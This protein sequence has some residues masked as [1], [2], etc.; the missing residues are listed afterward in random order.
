MIL[1]VVVN[2]VLFINDKSLYRFKFSICHQ[3]DESENLPQM[4]CDLCIIQLNVAYNFKC[5][6]IESDKKLEQFVIEKGLGTTS[7]PTTITS[8]SNALHL[9]H[10]PEHQTAFPSPIP[11]KLET[12]TD[13]MSEITICTNTDSD[14]MLPT[15]TNTSTT[16]TNPS[17]SSPHHQLAASFDSQSYRMVQLSN[18]IIQ[19]STHTDIDFIN[20]YLPTESSQHTISVNTKAQNGI[21]V[22][23]RKNV[24][25]Q[26]TEPIIKHGKSKPTKYPPRRSLR[27]LDN[28]STNLVL[29]ARPLPKLRRLSYGA[30]P[31]GAAV[32]AKSSN[33]R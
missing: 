3:I 26:N 14:T 25:H 15:L 8:P 17:S 27:E 18:Q 32:T 28:L 29:D 5:L 21:F 23:K 12:D 33:K 30:K 10:Q 2:F 24:L 22:A 20:T 6:A 19:T 11:I 1:R 16:N 7:A 4:L 31:K 13:S 9:T